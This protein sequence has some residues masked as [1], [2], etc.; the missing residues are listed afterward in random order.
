[1]NITN[2]AKTPCAS[3]VCPTLNGLKIM[4]SIPPAKLERGLEET[5]Y[6]SPIAPSMATKRRFLFPIF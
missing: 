2:S 4:I 5:V 3:I 1:L 6:H